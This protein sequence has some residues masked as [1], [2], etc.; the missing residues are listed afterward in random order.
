M[1]TISVKVPKGSPVINGKGKDAR[2]MISNKA[3]TLLV[4]ED[5]KTIAGEDY[6]QIADSEVEKYISCPVYIPVSATEEI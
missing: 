6:F 4:Y 1:K 5:R 3:E 2:I